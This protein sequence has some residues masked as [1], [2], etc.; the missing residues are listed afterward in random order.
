MPFENPSIH[1]VVAIVASPP[2][3]GAAAIDVLLFHPKVGHYAEMTIFMPATF[4]PYAHRLASAINA[5]LP[6][7]MRA[8]P[9]I[10]AALSDAD[11]GGDTAPPLTTPSELTASTAPPGSPR[12]L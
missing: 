6:E 5:A 11:E 3:G 2:V 12:T 10:A 1:R 4:R 8:R 9:D 7:A